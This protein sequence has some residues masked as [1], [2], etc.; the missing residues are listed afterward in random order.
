MVTEDHG[1]FA[2]PDLPAPPPALAK[3]QKRIADAI[4][5]VNTLG[6][7]HAD[8]IRALADAELRAKEWADIAYEMWAM[9]VNSSC[10]G[11]QSPDNLTRW[12]NQKDALRVRLHAALDKMP[13]D[14]KP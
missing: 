11:W 13:E 9:L 7:A 4:E 2:V 6:V 1:V 3:L 10:G 5:T 12:A 14:V 8:T